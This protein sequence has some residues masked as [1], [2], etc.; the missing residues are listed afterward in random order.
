[1][2]TLRL[3]KAISYRYNPLDAKLI[4][5]RVRARRLTS[6]INA[7]I[8]DDVS[9]YEVVAEREKLLRT[10]FGSMGQL[11]YVEPPLFVDYGC[12]ISVGDHFY[13]NFQ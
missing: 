6:K 3:V 11:I 12:N 7:P 1:M 5:G 13:S 9:I 10:L 8:P 4:E 2:V